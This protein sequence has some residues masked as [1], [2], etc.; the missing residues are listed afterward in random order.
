MAKKSEALYYLYFVQYENIDTVIS[1]LI[2]NANIFVGLDFLSGLSYTN[3]GQ[4]NSHIR[5]H[6]DCNI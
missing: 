1:A 6:I 4:S 3:D 5:V 2:S